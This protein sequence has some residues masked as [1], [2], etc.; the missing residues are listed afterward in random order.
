MQ[1]LARDIRAQIDSLFSTAIQSGEAGVGVA[2]L[3]RG[4][5]AITA[6]SDALA[7]PAGEATILLPAVAGEGVAVSLVPIATIA[8]IAALVV[9]AVGAIQLALIYTELTDQDD[10]EKVACLIAGYMRGKTFTQ[11]HMIDALQY[12]ADHLEGTLGQREGMYVVLQIAKLYLANGTNFEMSAIAMASALHLNNEVAGAICPC[13]EGLVYVFTSDAYSS[14]W[15]PTTGVCGWGHPAGNWYSGQGWADADIQCSAAEWYSGIDINL[16]LPEAISMTSITV[17]YTVVAPT[18][19]GLDGGMHLRSA[20]G[21]SDIAS[22]GTGAGVR[23]LTWT[24]SMMTDT[25]NL[26][27][28]SGSVGS[29]PVNGDVFITRVI[30]Q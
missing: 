8:A 25:I 1:I 19:A 24:G 29:A 14:E 7:L 3:S 27:C 28:N 15:V 4:P 5:L 13:D 2:L 26:A 6:V 9:A 18:N 11:A 30:I 23:S 16:T 17:E 10:L 20:S 12:S 22:T 21:G